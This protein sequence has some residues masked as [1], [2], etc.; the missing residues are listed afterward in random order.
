MK[1]LLIGLLN[2]IYGVLLLLTLS[3]NTPGFTIVAIIG[4]LLT[5]LG[6]AGC[7]LY[8][9]S[10]TKDTE[11]PLMK[12]WFSLATSFDIVLILGLLFRALVIQPFIVD[13]ISME[14]NFHNQEGLLVDKISYR[15]EKPHRGD[16]IIFKAPT[17]MSV[18]YIKRVIGLPGET[19]MI[20]NGKV[21]IN[22]SL[23]QETYLTAGTQT[24]T[25]QTPF[26]E[27][28]GPN[29]YFAMGDNRNDSSDSRSWGPV[30]VQNIIGRAWLIVYPFNHK[31][32]VRNP[33]PVLQSN[34]S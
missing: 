10:L 6:V 20:N 17:D 30:P 18:D 1:Y 31:G 13:G 23:L 29:E 12:S 9:L 25:S 19:V 22:G 14:T 27:T 33:A 26:T 15:F 7:V 5:I 21:Y 16:V 11:S 2:T 24:L 32:F 8:V 4:L 34:A 3:S 28:L